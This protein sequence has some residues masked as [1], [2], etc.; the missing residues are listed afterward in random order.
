MLATVSTA[1][2]QWQ[3]TTLACRSLTASAQAALTRLRAA[4]QVLVLALALLFLALV[5]FGLDAARNLCLGQ[6]GL[7]QASVLAIAAAVCAV[8]ARP[9]A[10]QMP[11][12]AAL[13]GGRWL[14]L[15]TETSLATVAGSVVFAPVLAGLFW[16]TAEAPGP[17]TVVR[18]L[19]L[20]VG[21]W[22]MS[23]AALAGR[24][25][26]GVAVCALGVAAALA[27]AVADTRMA[28]LAVVSL[29]LV[30]P[31]CAA[32]PRPSPARRMARS[33]PGWPG[34]LLQLLCLRPGELGLRLVL[35]TAATGLGL[36]WV[37]E[38]LPGERAAGLVVVA[39]AAG[40]ASN[41][42]VHLEAEF[43]AER[44]ELLAAL[45]VS[46]GRWLLAAFAVP[47]G[48]QSVVVGGGAAV[49]LLLGSPP[50]AVG[51]ASVMA[52]AAAAAALGIARIY[53]ENGGLVGMLLP[54][55]AARAV[56][57]VQS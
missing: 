33:W 30:A 10:P 14:L 27:T 54:L 28:A 23:W 9:H 56:G 39:G 15:G 32:R 2:A 48:L 20:L 3:L 5:W 8:L 4:M 35:A 31:W 51:V 37:A 40:L 17:G 44:S 16:A 13:P 34:L 6:G 12:I 1:R 11:E 45:P 55:L 18:G 50:A 25:W 46:E 57:A 21:L 47:F 38:W 52:L 26:Q 53:P 36:L 43:R 49:L 24:G 22:A 42:L 41:G 29:V 7:F 19:A